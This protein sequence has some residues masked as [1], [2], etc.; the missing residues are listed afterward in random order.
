MGGSERELDCVGGKEWGGGIVVGG[1]CGFSSKENLAECFPV[2]RACRLRSAV[3]RRGVVVEVGGL[4]VGCAGREIGCVVGRKGLGVVGSSFSSEPKAARTDSKK[5]A[6]ARSKVG[7]SSGWEGLVEGVGCVG[8]GAVAIAAAADRCCLERGIS[9][10]RR[11]SGGRKGNFCTGV[12]TV[13]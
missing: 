13:R 11:L 7:T 2:P 4:F 9:W 8:V 1:S 3:C 6:K 5:F 10:Q 12:A